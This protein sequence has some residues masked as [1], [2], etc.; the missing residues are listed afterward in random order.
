[1]K[2]HVDFWEEQSLV[3]SMMSHCTAFP[4]TLLIQIQ[5]SNRLPIFTQCVSRKSTD[6]ELKVLFRVSFTNAKDVRRHCRLRKP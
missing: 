2:L 4:G 5:S 1:M 3:H 6:A